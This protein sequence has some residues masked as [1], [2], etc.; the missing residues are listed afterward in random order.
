MRIGKKG[1]IYLLGIIGIVLST[2]PLIRDDNVVFLKWWLMILALGLGFLPLTSRLFA[3][4]E[5]KGWLFSKAIGMAVSGFV[6]WALVC[7]G[8][9]KFTAVTCLVTV[10]V[11]L[12][13]CWG[14]EGFLAARGKRRRL[15]LNLDLVLGEELVFLAVFFLWTYLAGFHPE[16]HGTEKFMDY[17]FMAAM[18]RSDTLPAPDIWYSLKDMNYYYG[19][20]Y[21]AVFLTKLSWSEV[22]D[23]Y[24]LMRTL[25]AGLLAGMSFSI[26][27]Q[28]VKGMNAIKSPRVKGV[29]ASLGGL[30]AGGAVVFAGN[31][32]YLIYGVIGKALGW[33]S[34]IDYWFPNSTRYIGYYPET[35]DKCIHEF[36]SY[37]FVLGD[38]HAHVVNTMFVIVVIGLMLSWILKIRKEGGDETTWNWKRCILDP[39]VVMGGFF[40]GIFQFTNYWD[41]V[42]YFTVIVICCIY[43][44]L[45]RFRCRWKPVLLSIVI[46]A[47]EVFAIGMVVALPFTLTF[48]N[49]VSGVGIAENHTMIRQ[50]LVLWGLPAGL[51]LIFIMFLLLEYR[52]YRKSEVLPSGEE[53]QTTNPESSTEE[54]AE[55]SG[56]ETGGTSVVVSQQIPLDSEQ[57]E[58]KR[59]VL[60]DIFQWVNSSDIFVFIIGMCALGLVLIP[61][62]VYV[63]DIYEDGYARSNTMFKLTY[64]GFIMFAV[65]MS[66]IILRLLSWKGR[67]L[68]K[69]LGGLGLIALLSTFGYF[70]NAVYSWFGTVWNPAEY[71]CQDATRYLEV[72][73]PEDA[74]AIRWLNEHVE[75]NPVVLEANGDSYSDY[76]R[77][78]A[79][80]GLPTV[81]GWYVH[82]WLWRGD[83]DDLNMRVA[84]I[85]S[86]YT[87][88]DAQQ[89]MS[90][91]EKY[92]V[93]Y[94]YVGKY[95]REKFPKLNEGVLQDLGELVY[96]NEDSDQSSG[97]T[98]V[99]KVNKS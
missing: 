86:I 23:T 8:I 40:I 73:F 14:L 95:E 53:V 46:Q 48:E 9:L 34:G 37:S 87:S 98:Y 22:A 24:N 89:V 64:Q 27:Y 82:E 36:P 62:V 44:N 1:L 51:L 49:M 59:R 77:V 32:H 72:A 71:R 80:T 2:L 43:I 60:A 30:L 28:L 35:N 29:T 57:R 66:Y 12:V 5:D 33:K 16:A 56:E 76:A 15:E 99:I 25:V 74:S 10:I 70:G 93:S 83:T 20:Q 63:R 58:P 85:E 13:L 47:T 54:S 38:L 69:V 79:M 78:S 96:Q 84:D 55:E 45:Y 81:L 6:V 41:F 52:K 94:I 88:Q 92:D 17:G 19:G 3:G 97:L 21:Y 31:L 42:I 18:M 50:W 91:L 68:S 4:F 90:L 65:A 67:K 75:G 61:E 7:A 11:C 39:H 26:V